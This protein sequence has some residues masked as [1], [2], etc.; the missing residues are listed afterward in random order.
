MFLRQKHYIKTAL[1]SNFPDIVIIWW[2]WK[3][4]FFIRI[5]FIFYKVYILFL[6]NVVQLNFSVCFSFKSN[7]STQKF[8]SK[9]HVLNNLK[10]IKYK[11]ETFMD[12]I[13]VKFVI[14]ALTFLKYNRISG[15]FQIFQICEIEKNIQTLLIIK[16][17]KWKVLQIA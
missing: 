16:I 17:F 2:F 1:Q 7:S 4:T 11:L 13:F 8:Q 10:L 6:L 12:K 3:N 14:F 9:N 5:I 15:T